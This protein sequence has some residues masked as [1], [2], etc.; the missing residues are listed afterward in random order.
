MMAVTG[1]K[2][3]VIKMT[4]ALDALTG[5]KVIQSIRW[6]KATTG[7]H[8]LEVTDTAGNT[9]LLASASGANVTEYYDMHCLP[10]EGIIVATMQSGTLVV[11]VA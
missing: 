4:A 6:I 7:G 2:T 11:Q 1:D 10:V 3:R 8:N 5:K 9:I